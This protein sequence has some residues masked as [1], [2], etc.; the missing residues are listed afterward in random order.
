MSQNVF[1]LILVPCFLAG[2]FI[3]E[4]IRN[5]F[6]LILKEVF[7]LILKAV[8][9]LTLAV[10]L[11]SSSFTS[12]PITGEVQSFGF[13][14]DGY[15]CKATLNYQWTYTGKDHDHFM[16][17]KDNVTNIIDTQLGL[18][19]FEYIAKISS[20]D[21]TG[22]MEGSQ[23]AYTAEMELQFKEKV[24]ERML[25]MDHFATFS[26][27]SVAITIEEFFGTTFDFSR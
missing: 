17:V 24:N 9:S 20:S 3:L 15:Y 18:L 14:S 6:L 2:S 8:F 22:I 21:L 19:F 12:E 10:G 11:L 23:I 25:D 7:S 26:L 16:E 1:S 27:E 5:V 4:L 13:T